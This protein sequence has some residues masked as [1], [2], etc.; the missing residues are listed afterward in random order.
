[1]LKYVQLLAH[2]KS[3][4]WVKW[5]LLAFLCHLQMTVHLMATCKFKAELMW[6]FNHTAVFGVPLLPIINYS[7]LTNCHTNQQLYPE[8]KHTHVATSEQTQ[9][10]KQLQYTNSTWTCGSRNQGTRSSG[11]IQTQDELGGNQGTRNS[12]K[13][14]TQEELGGRLRNQR[15]LEDTNSRWTWAR[16]PRNHKQLGDS[17]SRRT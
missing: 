8:E 4:M 14:P 9:E 3:S 10:T 1:M 16:G 13:L 2:A 5:K 17:N 15:Q 11:K 6:F 7:T 12:W